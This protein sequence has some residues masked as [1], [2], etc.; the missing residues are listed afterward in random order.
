MKQIMVTNRTYERAT[1]LADQLAGR[2]IPF[3]DM[4]DALRNVDIVIG[5]T[6]SPG[7]VLEAGA[8]KQAMS[9][10][11]Q[12]PLFMI[13]IAVPRDFDPKVREIHNVFLHDVDDLESASQASRMERQLEADGAEGIV[14]EEAKHFFE[15]CQDLEVLPTVA[16]LREKA[17]RIREAE[18]SKTLRRFN[19]KLNE[20]DLASLD[21][22]TRAIVN[23]LLHDPT[24]YLKG[25]KESR[26]LEVAKQI[27]DISDKEQ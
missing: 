24:V 14:E 15:W 4:P 23:K 25:G 18:L 1:E 26:N 20:E 9:D 3:Q 19:G 13:D 16:A 27:F 5:C 11:P 2:A 22:M 21:A 12:R 8:V 10:R 6:G 17:E 7:Y